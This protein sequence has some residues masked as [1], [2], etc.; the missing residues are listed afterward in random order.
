MHMQWVN[1][2]S[3]DSEF[4]NCMTVIAQIQRPKHHLRHFRNSSNEQSG[5]NKLIPTKVTYM[6]E[7]T[8]Y[9]EHSKQV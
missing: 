6:L 3:Q 7:V 8:T 1:V 9:Y 2:H 5:I 4:K